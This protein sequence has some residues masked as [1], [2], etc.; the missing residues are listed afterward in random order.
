MNHI[1]K[2]LL[3]ILKNSSEF[4][5]VRVFFAAS[6]ISANAHLSTI[7]KT[8]RGDSERNVPFPM[9]M[10]LDTNVFLGQISATKKMWVNQVC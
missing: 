8:L 5:Y 1:S 7:E 3:L 4:A 6:S 10:I 2:E 9:E